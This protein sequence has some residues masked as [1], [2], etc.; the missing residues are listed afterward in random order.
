MSNAIRAMQSDATRDGDAMVAR[1]EQEHPE[2]A[3]G[4]GGVL[5][6]IAL[7]RALK[8]VLVQRG[9]A[10]RTEKVMARYDDQLTQQ[11][12]TVDGLRFLSPAVLMQEALNDLA[13]TGN[14]RHQHFMRQVNRFHRE[15]QT[16]FTPKVLTNT[17]LTVQDYDQFPCF[18]FSEQSSSDLNPRLTGALLGLLLPTGMLIAF[19]AKRA[20]W[21]AM[22]G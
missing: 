1:Y 16:F 5:T 11:Q 2:V 7:E 10:E 14:G 6:G 12:Q 17:S 22:N 3:A 15:W 21:Y 9:A 13:E 18:S 20:R 19:N 4:D 8:R